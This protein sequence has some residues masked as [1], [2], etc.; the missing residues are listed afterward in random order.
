MSRP[1]A[2]SRVLSGFWSSITNS[3][4]KAKRYV[5]EDKWGNKFYEFSGRGHGSNVKR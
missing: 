4:A 3:P 2:W 5:G 1:S